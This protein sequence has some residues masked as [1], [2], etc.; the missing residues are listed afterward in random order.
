M[1]A[2]GESRTTEGRFVEYGIVSACP[3]ATLP[4]CAT[5]RVNLNNPRLWAGLAAAAAVT[6]I[7]YLLGPVLVPFVTAA[8]FG[9]V[10]HPAVERLAGGPRLRLPRWLAVTVVVCVFIVLLVSLLLL[11]VPVVTRELPQLREQVP[12]LL[13]RFA[14]WLA[15]LLAAWGVDVQL[16]MQGLRKLL[17][18]V[19]SDNAQDVGNALLSSAKMGGSLFLSVVGN[20]VLIPVVLFYLL[21]DW[22]NLVQ[23]AQS[24]IPTHMKA[25]VLGFID[26]AD[27]VLA[28][29]LRGQLLVMAIL[30]AYYSVALAIAGYDLALPIGLF[31]GLA[32]FVPYLG[33]GFGLLLAL[34]AGLLQLSPTHALVAVALIYGAGQVIEGFFL[35]PRLVGERIG[36]HPLAVIFALLSFGQLFGFVGVLIALPASAVIAVALRRAVTRYRAS[37]LYR[38]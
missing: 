2:E 29:F 33:F 5:R 21:M 1:A 35:T 22:A 28:Q 12:A 15:P 19:L 13:D 9:Y 36:L 14:R 20:L 34:L 18:Q 32:I 26:E 31:T 7:I 23:R 37:D 17:S 3:A 6:A 27:A 25:Q 4:H 30:A 8:V 11:V 10:L 38:T 24:L 16:D